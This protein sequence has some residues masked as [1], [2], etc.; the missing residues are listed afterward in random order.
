MPTLAVAGDRTKPASV[1]VN[2]P[3][4]GVNW[5]TGIRGSAAVAPC[6]N[7]T[8]LANGKR[9]PGRGRSGAANARV[10]I[11]PIAS[12]TIAAALAGAHA[13]ADGPVGSH[14]SST[15]SMKVVE[16][17]RSGPEGIAGLK[18][19]NPADDAAAVLLSA[20]QVQNGRSKDQKPAPTHQLPW[21]MPATTGDRT[22]TQAT[23]AGDS[24][25]S[26]V[27]ELLKGRDIQ[28][29]TPKRSAPVLSSSVV[30]ALKGVSAPKE[31]S[32]KQEIDQMLS[33]LQTEAGRTDLKKSI[34][35]QPK[36]ADLS[37]TARAEEVLPDVMPQSVA[38]LLEPRTPIDATPERD[39]ML[40][41]IKTIEGK[42]S[43]YVGLGGMVQSRNGQAG[44][45]RMTLQESTLESSNILS[46]RVRATVVAKSVFANTASPSG[47]SLLQFG[48]L[49][50][51]DTFE[52]PS[53]NGFGADLQISG[54]NYGLHFGSTPRGF[55]V[56]NVIGGFRIRP[57]GGPI[58]LTFDRDSVKDTIL[59]YAGARDPLTRRVWG[60]VI[61]N[62]GSASG[63][64]GDQKSGVY[65]NLGFQHL[66]GESVET[67]RRIDGTMGT[68][69][70]LASTSAGSLK[71]GVNLFAMHYAKNLRFFTVGHGG[72]FS[73]Q[74]FLLFNVPLNWTGRTKRL[75]YVVG[76]SIGSQSFTEEA[77]PFF[78]MDPLVQ[79]KT[80]P[81]YPKLSSSGINY[82]ID[83]RTAY[84]VAEN[85]FLVGFL[86]VNNARS[87]SQQSAGIS[88]K[89]SF[90]PRPL[91]TDL[92]IP[93]IPDWR[94]RQPFGIQ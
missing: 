79:G 54:T 6:L 68:Y 80:G 27:D 24:T 49:P 41:R 28:A 67:N 20:S 8:W 73:P 37:Q 88:I 62:T 32:S 42:D 19:G 86:N 17:L 71:A 16:S 39:R 78:P 25:R 14:R 52:A 23:I 90:R 4:S 89:Y 38:L 11:K 43:P 70:Q 35:E 84:Q 22:T 21:E 92:S 46:G 56:R 58:T 30:P 82:N 48:M 40:D 77:S 33:A 13:G 36:K 10:F 51:G 91:D 66:T 63:N 55:L 76:T 60:G 5:R 12:A 34:A 45:E 93:S 69:W 85:W 94:G 44:F 81:Y 53:A 1:T 18:A 29:S 87:Y 74:R 50:Q 59:S 57:A 26:L 7:G 9:G 47:E 61:A 31:R 65:F 2:P 72:Y 15:D 64:W 75:E 83:V 3:G